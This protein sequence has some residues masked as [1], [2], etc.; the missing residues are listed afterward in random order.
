MARNVL[1]TGFPGFIGQ[2]VVARL[3]AEPDTQVTCLVEPKFRGRAED[4]QAALDPR[5][6][7]ISLVTGDI[8]D[9]AL[10]LPDAQRKELAERINEVFHLAAVY[11]LAVEADLARRVNVGGTAN[12]LRFSETVKELRVLNYVSTV[13]VAGKR[14][15]VVFEEELDSSCGF[16][17]NYDETKHWAEVLVRA[18]MKNVPTI[19]LRPAVVVGDSKTGETE[20][21]DGPYL[22]IRALVKMPWVPMPLIGRADVPFNLAPVDFVADAMAHISKQDQAIGKTFHLADPNPLTTR[23]V[24]TAIYEALGRRPPGISIPES[25]AM[26]MFRT[27]GIGRALGIPWQSLPYMNQYTVFDTRNSEAALA[28]SGLCCPPFRSYVKTM[29]DFVS[30]HPDL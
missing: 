9:P 4:A 28:G 16:N 22:A 29:V 20:K 24:M 5:K 17:N 23:E 14:R 19:I 11:D 7:R 27:P 6:E 30:A 1:F 25:V 12:V 2:R 13:V 18:R 21:Y 26:A 10:G 15:G 3:L 8:A